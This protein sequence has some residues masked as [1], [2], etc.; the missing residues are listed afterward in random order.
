MLNVLN[1][2]VT[3]LGSPSFGGQNNM[4]HLVIIHGATAA[5]AAATTA[6]IDRL[7]AQHSIYICFEFDKK[8]VFTMKI[9]FLLI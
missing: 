8:L 1:Y 4:C 9:E 6:D 2:S 3:C 5:R 7:S